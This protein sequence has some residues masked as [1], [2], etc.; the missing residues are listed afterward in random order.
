[1]KE[2]MSGIGGNGNDFEGKPDDGS[3]TAEL[4]VP[5]RCEDCPYAEGVTR[6]HAADVGLEEERKD[7]AHACARIL[8]EYV[9]HTDELQRKL[10]AVINDVRADVERNKRNITEAAQREIDEITAS[11]PGLTATTAES[12]SSEGA[13]RGCNSPVLGEGKCTGRYVSFDR[14]SPDLAI[15]QA[16]QAVLA[17]RE[18]LLPDNGDSSEEGEYVTPPHWIKEIRGAG[19]D[20]S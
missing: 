9:G 7:V 12:Q 19:D 14:Y 5:K 16:R 10:D 11:C 3:G 2:C 1:M 8:L 20:E 17:L 6:E 15:E 13:F 4:D 18:S